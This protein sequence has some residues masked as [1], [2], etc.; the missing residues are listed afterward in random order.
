MGEWD[1]GGCTVCCADSVDKVNEKFVESFTL[2]RCDPICWL[3]EDTAIR[4]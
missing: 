3:P 2:I 1:N 4:L